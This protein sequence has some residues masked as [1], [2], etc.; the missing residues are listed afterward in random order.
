[1]SLTEVGGTSRA[2][3]LRSV[4]SCFCKFLL[5]A[6]IAVAMLLVD[7][8]A[9]AEAAKRRR[10]GSSRSSRAAAAAK[11][12]KERTIKSI[13]QQVAAARQVLAAAESQ[14]AMSQAQVNQA[15]SKLSGIRDDL[16]T[17][18]DDAEQ[19]AKTLH[20]IEAEILAEQQPD[21]DLGRAQAVVAQAKDDVHRE[22]HRVLRLPNVHEKP[23]D[24]ARLT[25]LA[26]LSPV[27]RKLLENDNGYRSA[28]DRM[29]EAGRNADQVRQKL[30]Q[31]DSNW[32]A[33]SQ[34]LAEAKKRSRDESQQAKTAGLSSLGDRRDLRSAQ[35]VAAAA[36]AIIAQ[37]EARL[38]QL[39]A[40]S[41]GG[42]SSSGTTPKR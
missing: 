6:L 23:G 5:V 16:E 20:E 40:K 8:S 17:G 3:A 36:R 21:S 18:H 25:D 4:R 24:A 15:L 41:S 39:G 32:V 2:D 26:N 31:A 29:R 42:G 33:A 30:L 14:T 28:Q 38:R 10:R 13:Q 1:M 19:A 9:E 22:I 34:D 12:R 11:A 27:Q 7:F 35:N 37:G